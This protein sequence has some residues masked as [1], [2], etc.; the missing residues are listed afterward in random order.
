MTKSSDKAESKASLAAAKDGNKATAQTKQSASGKTR[1]LKLVFLLI[2]IAA[3]VAAGW[4]VWVEFEQRVAA[5]RDS[6]AA[7]CFDS[8]QQ[9]IDKRA[10]AIEKRQA[11]QD[12]EV[13][14]TLSNM[15]LTLSIQGKRLRE[16]GATNGNDWLFAEALNLVRLAATRLQT[17]RS[18]KSSLALLENVDAILKRIDDPEL[19]SVRAAVADDIAALRLAGDIDSSG[20]YFEL[21]ALAESVGQLTLLTSTTQFVPA[22]QQAVDAAVEQPE[23]QGPIDKFIDAA[24]KL[25]RVSQR[26]Q[27]IEPLL[28]PSEAAVVRHNLR[29]MLE[30]A[31]SAVMRGDQAVYSHSLIK[32][33]DWVTRYFQYNSSA[34]VLQQRLASLSDLQIIQQLPNINGS[35]VAVESLVA[36]RNS[37]LHASDD[38]VSQ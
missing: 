34:E 22:A 1:G 23:V 32:A 10:L 37:R 13:R 19:L 16:L 20:L 29:L 28:Q 17:E 38:E 21:N 33:Q 18:T 2:V 36:L 15:R 30:Q 3:I 9:T 14:E 24:S 4:L 12:K 7:A 31:Q 35:L 8:A 25:I 11:R 27:P 26:S 5:E 6:V